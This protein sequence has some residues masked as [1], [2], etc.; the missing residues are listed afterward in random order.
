M[1]GDHESGGSLDLT[2]LTGNYK[3]QSEMVDAFHNDDSIF[4]KMARMRK[5]QEDEPEKQKVVNKFLWY[6]ADKT[7]EET[8]AVF[9]HVIE[10]KWKPDYAPPEKVPTNATP[11]AI[12]DGEEESE[13][14]ERDNDDLFQMPLPIQERLQKRM[15]ELGLL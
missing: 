11:V 10:G 3:S 7:L 12:D 13:C 1:F 2:Q 9:D 8:Q 6:F 5:I 14:L 15:A 4:K